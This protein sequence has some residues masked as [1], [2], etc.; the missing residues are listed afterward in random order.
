MMMVLNPFGEEYR[1]GG[2]AWTKEL[3]ESDSDGDGYTNGEELGDPCCE[4]TPFAGVEPMLNSVE[5][6]S[7]SHPGFPNSV[8]PAG[9]VDLDTKSMCRQQ[10]SSSSS[11]SGSVGATNTVNAWLAT[12]TASLVVLVLVSGGIID[13]IVM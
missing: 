10:S 5:G 2:F 6:F 12:T 1:A 4:W 13:T 7:P 11:S 8:P 3:C 9:F